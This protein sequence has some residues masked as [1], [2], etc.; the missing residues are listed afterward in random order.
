MDRLRRLEILVKV[1]DA[2]SFANAA[3]LLLITPSA[4][5][6]AITQLERELGIV[7]FYRTTRQLRLSTEGGEVLR[8][9]R[10][11][12]ARMALLDAVPASQRERA[13]GT[14]RIRSVH[15]ES[16]GTSS[17]RP[18]QALWSGTRKCRSR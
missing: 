7:A 3:R 8:H 2:G 18:C 11:V 14:L 12:L 4:V 9:A 6:H 1:A 17:C 15:R 10:D 16:R 13:A 5:S